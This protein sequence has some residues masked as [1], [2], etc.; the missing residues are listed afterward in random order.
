MIAGCFRHGKENEF[1]LVRFFSRGYPAPIMIADRNFGNT[2]PLT[3]VGAYPVYASTVLAGVHVLAM[4]GTALAMAAGA[5][6]VIQALQFS[7]A[8]V[9]AG[10]V[11]QLGSYAFVH[12][13]GFLFLLEIYMLVVFGK[14]IEQFLGRSAFLGIYAALLLL[15]PVVLT[16]ASFA[17]SSTIYFG[18]SALHFAVFVAFATLYPSA[19]MLF[20][21]QARW[22]AIL[23]VAVGGLQALAARDTAGMAFLL[24]DAGAAFLLVRWL[25]AG[26]S[27]PDLRTLWPFRRRPRLR[28]VREEPGEEVP[29]DGILE[30]IS[31]SGLGSL[32]GRERSELQKARERLLERDR[33][34]SHV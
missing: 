29:I 12:P 6:G 15:P 21:I 14:Q 3:W 31:R 9:R 33:K 16:L 19:E 7:S 24:L 8:G 28:V 20:G 32:T 5:E 17:G 4:V 26:G 13:P 23:L 22:A 1:P 18:S 34:R 25:Q 2:S 30:K 11:W 10:A 27:L